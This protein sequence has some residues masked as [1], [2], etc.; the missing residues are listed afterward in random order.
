MVIDNIMYA[1][2]VQ[3]EEHKMEKE[4]RVIEKELVQF[5]ED[6]TYRTTT[7]NIIRIL[8][9]EWKALREKLFKK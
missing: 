7:I 3:Q 8:P 6:H 1:I 4:I 2:N 5:M 9:F